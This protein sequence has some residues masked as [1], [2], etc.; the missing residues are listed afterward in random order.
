MECQGSLAPFALENLVFHESFVSGS[1]LAQ[2]ATVHGGFRTSFSIFSVKVNSDP[3]VD[4]ACS[5]H[6][7]LIIFQPS[8]THSCECSRAPGGAGSRREFDSRVTRHQHCTIHAP[9]TLT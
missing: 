5:F 4:A 3:E 6:E 7:L 9:M 1:H 8:R 2:S